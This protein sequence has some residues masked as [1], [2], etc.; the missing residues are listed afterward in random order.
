MIGFWFAGEHSGKYH[1]W[2]TPK[3]NEWMGA[4][5]FEVLEEESASLPGG[6][7]LGNRAKT[8]QITLNCFFEEITPRQKREI[9]KWLSKDKKGE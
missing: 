7:Y 8:R 3:N 2:W 1:V 4:E 9:L 6:Y 5:D